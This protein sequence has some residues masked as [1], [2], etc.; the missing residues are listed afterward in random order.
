[1][2]QFIRNENLKLYRQALEASTDLDQRR[3]LTTLLERLVVE[4]AASAKSPKQTT[5]I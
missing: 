3:V 2:Q 1:M 4:E 5:T